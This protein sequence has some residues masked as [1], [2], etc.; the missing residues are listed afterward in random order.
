MNTLC[1]VIFYCWKVFAAWHSRI[2]YHTLQFGVLLGYG[3]SDF[4]SLFW[5]LSTLT[6]MMCLNVKALLLAIQFSVST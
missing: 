2:T 1:S 4:I 6:Q 3:I 5:V